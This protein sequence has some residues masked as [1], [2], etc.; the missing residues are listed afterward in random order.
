MHRSK[1]TGPVGRTKTM[2][3][4]G[5]RNIELPLQ[6]ISTKE[7]RRWDFCAVQARAASRPLDDSALSC[8]WPPLLCSNGKEKSMKCRNGKQCVSL[9]LP[10]LNRIRSFQQATYC[11]YCVVAS[12]DPPNTYRSVVHVSCNS[13]SNL[14]LE[15][16]FY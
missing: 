15:M 3:P 9:P 7:P 5:A 6:R 10:N 2:F 14:V 13:L 12:K 1:T 16:P 11:T 4:F 8:F